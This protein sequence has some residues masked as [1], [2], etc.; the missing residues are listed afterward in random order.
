MSGTG[1]VLSERLARLAC[2]AL[3]IALILFG[4]PVTGRLA[5]R[6]SGDEIVAAL[7]RARHR[8]G[9]HATSSD[10]VRRP[11]HVRRTSLNQTDRRSKGE[12]FIA[13]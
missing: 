5:N 12:D 2:A 11:A 4:R 13:C 1:D 6:M 8:D 10:R 3:G 7:L 9:N